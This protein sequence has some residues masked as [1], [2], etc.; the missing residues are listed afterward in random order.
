LIY[1]IV[2]G[3]TAVPLLSELAALTGGRSFVLRDTRDLDA[4]LGAVARELRHQYLLGYVPG[5][6][7]RGPAGAWHSI[8][9]RVRGQ[10]RAGLRVRARDGYQSGGGSPVE[11]IVR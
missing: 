3:R 1:P 2:F 5:G 9:V 10:D 8:R 6:A 7:D 11:P 4:T